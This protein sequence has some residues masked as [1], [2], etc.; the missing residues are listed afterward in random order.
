MER[1]IRELLAACLD[2][3]RVAASFEIMGVDSTL[4]DDGTYFVVERGGQIVGCGGWSRR[5]TMF[6]GDH[7]SGRNARL[8]DPAREPARIRAM[9]T[10]PEFVRRGIGRLVLSLCETA[11]AGEGFSQVE[12]VATT[13]GEPLYTACGFTVVE[14]IEVPTS[15]GVTVPCARMVK[16]LAS[17]K[18][19]ELYERHAHAFDRDRGKTLQEKAW[20]DRFVAGLPPRATVLDVG[21]GTGEPIARYLIG[22]GFGVVGVDS[23]ST[24][25]EICRARFPGAE[26]Q[27][28]DM[29]R[30]SLGRRFDGIIAWDSFFHL[31]AEQQ[32]AMFPRFAEHARPGA[33]LMFTSGG[34]AG[35]AIGEYCGEPLFH[36]SL[37]PGEY[38]ELLGAHGFQVLAHVSEDPDCGDH[39]IWLARK[40]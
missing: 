39:T 22:S 1:S 18:V 33:A 13:A 15:R 27:V 2:A 32:R 6:G 4:I 29:R 3:P 8:L 17:E 19:V 16:H 14:R 21:C 34:A 31:S 5:A 23:S 10:D 35:E 36:A 38:Q 7:T 28:A 25:I 26:W 37:D 20:L 30:L 11:A 24:M 9:Y 40:A 12:L